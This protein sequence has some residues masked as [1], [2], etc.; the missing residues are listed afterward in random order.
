MR[1]AIVTVVC[2]GVAAAAILAPASARG[3]DSTALLARYAPVFQLYSAD[4]KPSAIEPFLAGADLER[5]V[6]GSWRVVRRSPPPSALAGGSKQLRLNTRGCSPAVSPISC[7]TVRPTPTTIYG[8]AWTGSGTAVN[9]TVLQYWLFYGLDDWRNSL[10]KPT[11]WYLHEGDWEEVSVELGP[12][13]KPVAVS[14]SQHDMG[15]NRPW[16]RTPTRGGTH[17]VV[18]VALGSHANYLSPGYRG[19]AGVPHVVPTKFSGVPLPQPDF[20]S[21]QISV[22]SAAIVDVS[23]G[24]AP[25]LSFAGAWGDGSYLLLTRPGSKTPFA[26]LRVGDSPP[27]P[28]LHGIWRDP[29]QQF[30]AWPADD[31][32]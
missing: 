5:L 1:G 26:R 11:I 16:S 4:L 24:S 22:R 30:R 25:W 2:T 14:V 28:A 15:V 10:T 13:G 9:K 6:G 27:G 7:Y 20:T 32:H 3:F 19:E 18:Y 29:L 12:Y 23:D 31:G 8:R 21:A 17:P